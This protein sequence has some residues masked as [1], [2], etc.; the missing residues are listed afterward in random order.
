M[1]ALIDKDI[2]AV[3]CMSDAIAAGAYAVLKEKGLEPGRDISVM[4]YDNQTLSAHLNPEL[5]T[6][7]LPLNDI[8]YR[9]AAKIIDM[10]NNP[11]SVD[12]EKT[13]IR[14]KSRLI[15]RNSVKNIK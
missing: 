13:D 3:F 6:M 11:L 14:I 5:S 4:G 10:I 7:A 12:K 15:E 8:G 2:T 9:A 1:K